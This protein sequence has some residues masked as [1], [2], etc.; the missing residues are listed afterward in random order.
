MKRLIGLMLCAGLVLALA[1]EA[2]AGPLRRLLPRNW[3][4]RCAGSSCSTAA[5]CAG[6]SCQAAVAPPPQAWPGVVHPPAPP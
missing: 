1:G 4:S 6:G 5:G 3:G 2:R